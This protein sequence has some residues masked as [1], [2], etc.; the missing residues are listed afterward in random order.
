MTSRSMAFNAAFS[1]GRHAGESGIQSAPLNFCKRWQA[2]A[3]LMP[4][5]IGGRRTERLQIPTAIPQFGVAAEHAL[6]PD[7]EHELGGIAQLPADAPGD[8]PVG[9]R[10]RIRLYVEILERPALDIQH[11]G[12]GR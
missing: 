5:L 6:V 10:F 1:S 9:P 2:V 4:L 12:I 3:R 11:V 7:D 8:L